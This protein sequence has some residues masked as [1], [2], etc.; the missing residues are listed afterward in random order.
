MALHVPLF[1]A[2]T[3]TQSVTAVP[4]VGEVVDLWRPEAGRSSKRGEDG[5]TFC[6]PESTLSMLTL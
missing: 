5:Q 1:L 6:P 3:T 2:P 4:E